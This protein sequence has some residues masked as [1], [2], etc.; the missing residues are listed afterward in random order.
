MDGSAS[1]E[2]K[3]KL[4]VLCVTSVE[5]QSKYHAPRGVHLGDF[6]QNAFQALEDHSEPNFDVPDIEYNDDAKSTVETFPE[7][8]STIGARLEHV[9][10]E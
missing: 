3:P 4:N 8:D 5:R 6:L 10:G 1:A 7:I 9:R 2:V